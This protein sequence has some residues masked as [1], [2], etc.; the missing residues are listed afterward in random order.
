MV[1]WHRQSCDWLFLIATGLDGAC[2]LHM[3]DVLSFSPRTC[4]ILFN[5]LSSISSTRFRNFSTRTV[6]FFVSS[7][8][9]SKTENYGKEMGNLYS[10]VCSRRI[11]EFLDRPQEPTQGRSLSCFCASW[12]SIFPRPGI[13]V[14][15]QLASSHWVWPDS[16]NTA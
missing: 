14:S 16:T 15:T 13:L 8:F 4:F 7:R 10:R 1:P 11:T 3:L 6:I 9:L 5:F 12:R 2:K